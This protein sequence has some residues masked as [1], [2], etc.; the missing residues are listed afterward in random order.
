MGNDGHDVFISYSRLDQ[1][2]ALE[3]EAILRSNGLK[4]FFDLSGLTPGRPWVRDL[5]SAI[6]S[7]KS[8]IIL[9]GPNGL[10]N[11]QQYERSLALIRHSRDPSFSVI[12][13]FLPG[14]STDR[15]FDFLELLTWIDF[16]QYS[17]ISDA[18]PEIVRLLQALRGSIPSS[19]STRLAE[20]PCPY[21]GLDAFREEDAAFFF[22]R[23]APEDPCSP[24]G[25]LIQKVH[26]YPFVM[27]VGRSGSGKS[28]L[29]NSGLFPALR[30]DRNH[31]WHTVS[32][33]PG[34]AP[35]QS[36]AAVFNPRRNEGAAEYAQKISEEAA[37]FRTGDINILSQVIKHELAQLEGKPDR[38]LLYIDQ[39]EELYTLGPPNCTEQSKLH[40]S[41]VVRF[42]DLLLKT[43]EAGPVSIVGTVRA[44]FYDPLIAHDGLK[45]ILPMRQ[46]LLGKMS[47]DDLEQTIVRPAQRVGVS[48]DPPSLVARILDDAGEDDGMLPLLQ[49]ALKE[50]WRLCKGRAISADAYARCGGVREAIRTTAENN[51]EPLPLVEKAAA[52]R[53]FLRLVTAGE[54]QED[55]R[56][57][58]LMPSDPQQ[59]H[60]VT[61]FSDIRTRLLVTGSDRSGRP[62]VEIAHEALIRTWPRLRDW[63]NANR[64]QLRSRN[65]IL[66]AKSDWERNGRRD[67]LLLPSG[68]PL[69][70]ARSL[71]EDPGDLTTDDL[72]E[73]VELSLMR[74]SSAQSAE[75]AKATR[76]LKR[77]VSGL[78]TIA[79]LVGIALVYTFYLQSLAAR[80]AIAARRAEDE[81][82]QAEHRARSASAHL[83]IQ[84]RA[85]VRAADEAIRQSLAAGEK[86]AL[87]YLGTST[88]LGKEQPTAAA[89]AILNGISELAHNPAATFDEFK[90][91]MSELSRARESP[92]AVETR[93][94]AFHSPRV[95]QATTSSWVIHDVV[96]GETV[97]Q[98]A[99]AAQATAG[100]ITDLTVIWGDAAGLVTSA[101]ISTG[102]PTWSRQLV[103]DVSGIARLENRL[104][105]ASRNS[106][107]LTVVELTSGSPVHEVSDVSD[108][109]CQDPLGRFIIVRRPNGAVAKLFGTDSYSQQDLQA[110]AA[111]TTYASISASGRRLITTY[112]RKLTISD[113]QH[114]L[115][116]YELDFE[117]I[118]G[119]ADVGDIREA[120]MG[121]DDSSVIVSFASGK[122]LQVSTYEIA[123]RDAVL[124][125]WR[126]TSRHAVLFSTSHSS[127]DAVLMAPESNGPPLT[128]SAGWLGEAHRL[129][130]M[131]EWD[132]E[133][134]TSISSTSVSGAE[135]F[136]Q[137]IRKVFADA[138]AEKTRTED[139]RDV[140][141]G[142]MDNE[143]LDALLAGAGDFLPDVPPVPLEASE[144]AKN[145]VY[146]EY[147]LHGKAVNLEMA[148][149]HYE[150]AVKEGDAFAEYRLAVILESSEAKS[151]WSRA[152]NLRRSAMKKGLPLAFNLEGTLY[153]SGQAGVS[154]DLDRAQELFEQALRMGDVVR[155][156]FNLANILIERHGDQSSVNRAENLLRQSARAGNP[157]A[158]EALARQITRLEVNGS[159]EEL[160]GFLESS[161]RYSPSA[162]ERYA[163]ELEQRLPSGDPRRRDI[164]SLRLRAAREQV[165]SALAASSQGC[166]L[167][168]PGLQTRFAATALYRSVKSGYKSAALE[169]GYLLLANGASYSEVVTWFEIAGNASLVA[170]A[171]SQAGYDR[172]SNGSLLGQLTKDIRVESYLPSESGLT[173]LT[174]YPSG[175]SVSRDAEGYIVAVVVRHANSEVRYTIERDAKGF[176]VALKRN[177]ALIA[178]MEYYNSGLP[179]SLRLQTGD[180]FHISEWK[181]SPDSPNLGDESRTSSK[182]LSELAVGS[183]R[184][185]LQAW[186][187]NPFQSCDC[188]N[189]TL[190]ADGP[191]IP[192]ARERLLDALQRAFSLIEPF[193]E[194]PE[195]LSI[196]PEASAWIKDLIND[197]SKK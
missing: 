83:E 153:E 72:K 36:L 99:V 6:G 140:L 174:Q 86:A 30:L 196:C 112:G 186:P 82:N 57:R 161:S 136:C 124:S 62:T 154:R 27:V 11:T 51:Y 7:A 117:K 142:L 116:L 33:R 29:V 52:R 188:F 74:E 14:T 44:D 187:I 128:W 193:R 134:D 81:A 163:F 97:Q 182:F 96:S 5:E 171:R 143:Q 105:I 135:K 69:E 100:L 192:E 95:L 89:A 64:D 54:G 59:R 39:W 98:M 138:L 165:Y 162:A 120:V 9:I 131:T 130:E 4:A 49:Y 104:F 17:S 50:T 169:L 155:A 127:L 123:Q 53:L 79:V 3:L 111:G 48:F 85:A 56:A 18:T 110:I 139:V 19:D 115:A 68:L 167:S 194:L 108:V 43:A 185:K 157:Y 152:A 46:L 148:R 80:E 38:L 156:P 166:T 191:I 90:S 22:G 60:I 91:T 151:D 144:D 21:R 195:E 168:N 65:S 103:G 189:H 71:L 159:E 164:C 32:I 170:M 66:Q 47:R 63:I 31:F 173:V 70:R 133:P 37:R 94:L 141:S 114:D 58:A 176:P 88:R 102:K 93:I 197:L 77:L 10:G 28:S 178:K 172:G 78:A 118:E 184:L 147:G 158:A 55:T 41:D 13:I 122:Y 24:I 1:R 132:A 113:L 126:S 101:D 40:F 180:S 2:Y 145:G 179:K 177:D 92:E 183:L 73:Y 20:I 42:V 181:G 137:K 109:L 190:E 107:N 75:R 146:F 15:P 129:C 87:V 35:L 160:L 61:Q 67:D 23:G 149:E 84:R 12:P 26:E 16:S 76:R 106:S 119:T 175:P 34:S 125:S 8:A 25:E 121:S 150:K 45:A